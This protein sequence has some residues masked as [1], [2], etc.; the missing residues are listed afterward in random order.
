MLRALLCAVA[1]ILAI[2]GAE[3]QDGGDV[4]SGPVT[5][6]LPAIQPWAEGTPETGYKGLLVDMVK[7]IRERTNLTIDFHL[8]PHSRAILEL[9]QG[10]ADFVPTFVAPGIAGLGR[11][12]ADIVS[13]DVLVLGRVSDEPIDA[14]A[15]LNGENVGYL[16][17][18]WYGQTFAESTA[19]HKVPV[20]NVAHGLRRSSAGG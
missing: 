12:V 13:L 15:D 6:S 8:R 4:S 5:F 20:N 1:L 19:I 7:E 16:S 3:A 18:T 14:L 9:E 10:A 2:P 17:G 11:P